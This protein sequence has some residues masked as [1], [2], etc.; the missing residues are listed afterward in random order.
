MKNSERTKF[1]RRLEILF[2]AYNVPPTPVRKEAYWC[3]LE[4]CVELD[5]F[6]IVVDKLLAEPPLELPNTFQLRAICTPQRPLAEEIRKKAGQLEF[7]AQLPGESNSQYATQ[8]RLYERNRPRPNIGNER[9]RQAWAAEFS[10][11][12]GDPAQQKKVQR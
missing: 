8:L 5:E 4:G 2:A 1:D 3:A 12:F 9:T 11:R 10:A 7:R 6:V